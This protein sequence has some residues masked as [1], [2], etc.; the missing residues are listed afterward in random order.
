MLY[1]FPNY[2]FDNLKSMNWERCIEIAKVYNNK[3]LVMRLAKYQ[4]GHAK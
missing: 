1:L 2:Y 3:Q 4:K